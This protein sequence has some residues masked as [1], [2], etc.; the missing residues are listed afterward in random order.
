MRILV[1]G[2]SVGGLSAAIMCR[3]AGFQVDVVEKDRDWQVAGAGITVNGSTLRALGML[4]VLGQVL[5]RGYF[6]YGNDVVDADDTVLAYREGIQIP[7]RVLPSGGGIMRPVL[8]DILSR[9]ALAAGANVSVGTSYTQIVTH[10]DH[11]AVQFTNGTRGDYDLVIAADGLFSETR[12]RF[13][14]GAPVPRFTG[15]GCWRVVTDRPPAMTR[16][17]FYVGTGSAVGAVPVSQDEMYVWVLEHAPGNPWIERGQEPAL[18]A[19]LL[20][21]FS[22]TLAHVREGLG[23]QSRILYRPLETVMLPTPWYR[24]RILLIGDAAHGTTPHLASG[25]GLAIEDGIAIAEELAGATAVAEAFERFGRRRY[26]RCAMV[27]NSSVAIGAA[28]IAGRPEEAQAIFPE[29]W[30]ALSLPF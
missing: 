10:A 24:D 5:E 4:G 7:G 17:R 27:V 13:F 3:H 21:P 8:H 18:L 22:G 26:D 20:A 14:P 19:A 1:V 16:S 15:Q 11:V 30:S 25:A 9:Q 12:K 23:A 29:A 2:G 6:G 28:Q